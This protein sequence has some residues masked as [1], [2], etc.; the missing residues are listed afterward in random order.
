[1]RHLSEERI[2]EYLDSSPALDRLEIESHLLICFECREKLEQYKEIYGSL[3]LDSVPVPDDSFNLN[4]LK[5]IE[6]LEYK[7]ASRKLIYTISSLATA[8]L[9][10]ILL[11][12]FGIL[13]WQALLISVKSVTAKLLSPVFDT[14]SLVTEKL[15]GN[16]ELLAFAA[17]ALLL[18]QLLDYGLVRHRIKRI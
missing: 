4:I 3:S 7:K 12:L 11:S 2:Q 14:A 5:E 10:M 1:M 13:N 15:N 18:F 16:L 8:A 9:A 6:R 17:A